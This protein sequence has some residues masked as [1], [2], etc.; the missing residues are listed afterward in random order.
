MSKRFW[1]TEENAEY[2][3]QYGTEYYPDEIAEAFCNYARENNGYDPDGQAEENCREALYYLHAICENEYNKDY[4]RTLYKI[5]AKVTYN[6][7]GRR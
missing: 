3:E 6:L 5:L 4:F 7:Q 2:S 1:M